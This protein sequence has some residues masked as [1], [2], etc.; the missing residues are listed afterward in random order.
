MKL[1]FGFSEEWKELKKFE[2]LSKDI[3]I[4]IHDSAGGIPKDVLPKIFEPYFTTKDTGTG[5][6]LYM[7]KMIIDKDFNGLL[8]VANT[9]KGAKF[10]INLPKG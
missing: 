10:T 2:N 1:N 8:S 5:I 7:S 6:G 4:R 9:D 3:M